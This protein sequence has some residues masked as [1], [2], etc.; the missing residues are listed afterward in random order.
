MK[1]KGKKKELYISLFHIIIWNFK[2]TFKLSFLEAL[3]GNSGGV[4][5]WFSDSIFNYWFKNINFL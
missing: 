1:K 5:S 2:Y 4:E 3:G